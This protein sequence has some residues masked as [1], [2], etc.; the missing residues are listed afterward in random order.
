M[1]TSRRV[2][3]LVVGR[4]QGVAFRAHCHAEAE[5]LRLAGFVRNRADGAVEGEAEGDGAQVA[6]FCEWLHR[7]SPWSKVE[8][9]DVEEL[10]ATGA[11]PGF[12]VRR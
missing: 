3:F 1:S 9:V 12:G 5:R 7:G 10:G 2:A 11:P 4:V 8:R 6:A